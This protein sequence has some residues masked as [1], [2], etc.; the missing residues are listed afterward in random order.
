MEDLKEG[1]AKFLQEKLPSGEK[2]VEE[3]HDENKI[4]V[5]YDF[6]DSN[7]GLKPH[8]IPKIDVRKFSDKDIVT[9]ILQMEQ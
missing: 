2:L 6:I 3:T 9:W 5:N 4:N 8:Y 7:V 1:L